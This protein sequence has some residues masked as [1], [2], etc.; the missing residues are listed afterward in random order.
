MYIYFLTCMYANLRSRRALTEGRRIQSS[1][2][3]EI[4]LQ[5]DSPRLRDPWEAYEYLFIERERER[6]LMITI[7]TT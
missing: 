5:L 1:A 3:W 7:F 2:P 4:K 6:E